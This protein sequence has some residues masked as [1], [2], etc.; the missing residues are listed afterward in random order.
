[1]LLKRSLFT[2]FFWSIPI[3][4]DIFIFI[5]QKLYFTVFLR[6]QFKLEIDPGS[7]KFWNK[8]IL[9]RQGKEQ[10]LISLELEEVRVLYSKEE[11]NAILERL[12]RAGK[13]RRTYCM[14]FLF[15]MNNYHMYGI[16][17]ECSCVRSVHVLFC[18]VAVM[19]FK[20]TAPFFSSIFL[21]YPPF[22]S[23]ISSFLFFFLHSFIPSYFL[24]IVPLILKNN[25]P[26]SLSHYL[27]LLLS[28]TFPYTYIIHTKIGKISPN[29]L[30]IRSDA[31]ICSTWSRRIHA[32]ERG[33][34]N[35]PIE[36]RYP[37]YCPFTSKPHLRYLYQNYPSV[38]GKTIFRSKDR[39]Y[40]TKSII[41]SFF[42]MGILK[43]EGV[44][45][46]LIALHDANR[47]DR[48]TIGVCVWPSVRVHP[49][50]F[51][52]IVSARFF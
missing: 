28:P 2:C 46:D 49:C 3:I 43:E 29:D 31:E 15:C 30:M 38:R 20:F 16:S 17:P 8:E 14:F 4:I 7:D 39:L 19:Q 27:F 21:C 1:M 37:T 10:K 22:F 41:D 44:I 42:D 11:A 6:L 9:R 32:L 36:N 40:L 34:D 50:G 23:S 25:F 48:L 47:G 13:Y 45:T 24:S 51:F 18:T 26:F 35:I 52:C 33:A 5:N 12:Y